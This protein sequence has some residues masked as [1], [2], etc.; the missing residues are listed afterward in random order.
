M[1]VLIKRKIEY[2]LKILQQGENRNNNLSTLVETAI[3][4]I[5]ENQKKLKSFKILN[6]TKEINNNISDLVK[7][8]DHLTHGQFN[9]LLITSLNAVKKIEDENLLKENMEGKFKEVM[10]E[11]QEL[12]KYQKKASEE[13]NISKIVETAVDIITN[14]NRISKNKQYIAEKQEEYKDIINKFKEII[15][16]IIQK[17]KDR[18]KDN[19]KALLS[20]AID[21]I[22]QPKS[23]PTPTPSDAPE[24]IV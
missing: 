1:D 6:E 7:Q 5:K 3:E 22:S 19:T 2:L 23:L 10:S 17:N 13:T 9:S 20:T 12:S 21:I 15:K 11:L 18:Q 4:V 16:K 24:P 14:N 8:N